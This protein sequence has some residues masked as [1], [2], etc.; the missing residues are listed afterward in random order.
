MFLDMEHIIYELARTGRI[1]T[2]PIALSRQPL[3]SA[4]PAGFTCRNISHTCPSLAPPFDV[5]SSSSG[6][7]TKHCPKLQNA[8]SGVTV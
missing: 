1:G 3:T 6:V 4:S 8:V 2:T 7:S 5:S